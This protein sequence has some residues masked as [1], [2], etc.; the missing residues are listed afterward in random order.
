MTNALTLGAQMKQAEINADVILA[1][2][3]ANSLL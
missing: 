3:N 1:A 2:L